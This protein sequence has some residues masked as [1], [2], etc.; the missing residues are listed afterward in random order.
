MKQRTSIWLSAVP[1]CLLVAGAILP[2]AHA[3]NALHSSDTSITSSSSQTALTRTACHVRGLDEQVECATLMVPENYSQPAGQ[4]IALNIVRLPAVS[5]GAAA[6]PLF[7]LAGGPGQ[8]AT[9]LAGPLAQ[10]FRDVRQTR[11]IVFIDQRGTGKSNPLQCE[12][13]VLS[14]LVLPDEDIDFAAAMAAC[15]E[16]FSADFSQYTTVNAIRDFDAV[17]VALGYATINLYGGSYGSRAALV[18]MREFPASIR[19]A[20]LDGVAPPQVVVG[21]FGT[22]GAQAFN[23]LVSD[24]AGEAG[25][26]ATFGDLAER[27]AQ[28]R[29]SLQEQPV[30]LQLSDPRSDEPR[31][32]LMTAKRFG[33]VL[34]GALYSPR[35][36]QLLPLAIT[37]ASEGN[38]RPMA[39]LM[40]AFDAEMPMYI[41]LT[42]S[43]LC[44]EDLPRAT[45]ELLAADAANAFIGGDTAQD[46]LAMCRG[47]PVTPL[48]DDS[49]AQPVVSAIP[50]L[51]LSGEQDPVTP[52]EWAELAAETLSNSQHLVAEHGGHTIMSHTCANRLIAQFLD[53]PN[54]ELD[55]ACLERTRMLPFIRNVNAAGM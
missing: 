3:A 46:F 47:W 13:S 25:C 10:I 15:A 43:V 34:R 50:S 32:L 5:S 21:P 29:A 51:L 18:Y 49:H 24:C 30:L 36:R 52:P 45:P 6:D 33:G 22:F 20:V 48:A 54:R 37:A 16:N 38:W 55:G 26:S 1:L 2:S 53:N 44:Q 19:S 9:E 39:G 7:F 40:G 28:L 41:G 35:T 31:E 17:R 8:A 27:Y 4:Q 14:D 42:T 12:I 11:D 23:R